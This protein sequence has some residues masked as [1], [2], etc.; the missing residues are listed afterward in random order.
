MNRWRVKT[1]TFTLQRLQQD[2]SDMFQMER[3]N[4]PKDKWMMSDMSEVHGLS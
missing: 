2:L 1:D 3:S 4:A